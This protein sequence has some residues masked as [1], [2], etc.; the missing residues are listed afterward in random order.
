MSF[1][2]RVVRGVLVVAT[3]AVLAAPFAGRPATAR[4]G[5]DDEL[6]IVRKMAPRTGA[7]PRFAGWALARGAEEEQVEAAIARGCAYLVKTQSAKGSWKGEAH[8]AYRVGV[9]GL[10]LL[11][12]MDA[13]HAY[14]DDTVEGRAL[15][16]GIAW[17][18]SVQD[19]EGCLGS[20]QSGRYIYN[21]AYGAFALI[22]AYALS[23]D[24][25]VKTAAQEAIRFIELARNPYFAWRYGIKPGDND[26]DVMGSIM[27]SVNDA[28][29]MNREAREAEQDEPFTVDPGMQDGAKTWIYKI[30]DFNTGRA[31]YLTRG[32]GPCRY[33]GMPDA[34]PR[35]NSETCTA[36]S[37]WC[38]CRIGEDPDKN[39]QIRNGVELIAKL[40]PDPEPHRRAFDQWFWA[41][42]ARLAS[43]LDRWGAKLAKSLDRWRTAVVV[44]LLNSQQ[45]G[46]AAAPTFGSWRPIGPWGKDGGRIYSTALAITTLKT[47]AYRGAA[48]GEGD[49]KEQAKQLR[50]SDT[51]L[52]ARLAM[53]ESLSASSPTAV[54]NALG[55]LV[56][57]ASPLIRLAAAEALARIGRRG[58]GAR[59]AVAR[60]VESE[61]LVPVRQALVFA[62][63]RIGK[64]SKAVTSA[65]E[66]AVKDEDAGVRMLA[67][68]AKASLEAGGA[69]ESEPGLE[70]ASTAA[71][72]LA[73]LEELGALGLEGVQARATDLAWRLLR[74]CALPRELGPRVGQ[75][76]ALVPMSLLEQ[77]P[78]L[79]AITKAIDT[80]AG[81]EARTA[82]DTALAAV[83]A[84]KGSAD[85]RLRL[86]AILDIHYAFSKVLAGDDVIIG[87][88][89]AHVAALHEKAPSFG[90]VR[91]LALQVVE[92]AAQ[93][94][95]AMLLPR[96]ATPAILSRLK[97]TLAAQDKLSGTL[98]A[99]PELKRW[100]DLG[101]SEVRYGIGTR[102]NSV[103]ELYQAWTL[104]L[105]VMDGPV[106]TIDGRRVCLHG[107]AWATRLAPSVKLSRLWKEYAALSPPV[108]LEEGTSKD[109][110]HVELLD[111][112]FQEIWLSGPG[113][114]STY[115]ANNFVVVRLRLTPT[116]DGIVWDEKAWSPLVRVRAGPPEAGQFLQT[117]VPDP[118]VAVI[119]RESMG[120]SPVPEGA[121]TKGQPL[122]TVHVFSATESQLEEGA[123]VDVGILRSGS[124]AP[125]LVGTRVLPSEYIQRIVPWAQ[126]VRAMKSD[127]E[128]RIP[129]LGV[130]REGTGLLVIWAEALLQGGHLDAAKATAARARAA[131]E[132]RKA[133]E[134]LERLKQL[135]ETMDIK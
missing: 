24:E 65:L 45:G 68:I 72:A 108:A 80:K 27:L 21:H 84:A 90:E 1:G 55:T 17:L 75:R 66:R 62:L 47:A 130:T 63:Y 58:A 73:R 89:D 26:T 134:L 12:L 50:A 18:R 10:A 100:I 129:D 57:D 38:R 78:V 64:T 49:A 119:D 98:F 61:K 31:G 101:R 60:R 110:L 3:L 69:A 116:R 23:G 82:Y 30:T 77:P 22:R 102:P 37:A 59:I 36:I 43:E 46:D 91:G 95:V 112:G 125:E 81:P 105:Q 71:M 51:D 54:V 107:A 2:V 48:S 70:G 29:A 104:L 33:E 83:Q 34:Y 35:E 14:V 118:S 4:E 113:G 93:R 109:G 42:G 88:L 41:W 8:E 32:T 103:E 5:D 39:D 67:R 6:Y 74:Q 52:D 25:K 96:E 76:L 9:T 40:A 131:A 135:E 16:R 120:A 92:L 132:A 15:R 53:I 111:V 106:D 28:Y 121:L 44:A 13:G 117:F 19:Q 123:T 7:T 122:V 128:V 124:S 11:A 87:R 79:D 114:E 20:R 97:A 56:S 99:Y 126:L 133:S 127:L 85:D 94:A 86:A 115:S